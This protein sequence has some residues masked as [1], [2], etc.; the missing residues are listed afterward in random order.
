MKILVFSDTHGNPDF[1]LEAIRIHLAAAPVSR[2]VHLGDGW[3]DFLSVREKYPEIPTTAVAGNGEDAWFGARPELPYS[4]TFTVGGITFLAA[5]GHR[6]HVKNDLDIAA[7]TA[8]R[9]GADVMLF[10]H[11]HIAEDVRRDTLYGKTVRMINPGSAGSGYRPSYAVLEIAYGQ[12]LCGFGGG[13][14]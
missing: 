8:A 3:R 7:N 12:L 9:M 14:L 4:E 13:N 11:T 5:H 1:M 10:G 6:M 2:I